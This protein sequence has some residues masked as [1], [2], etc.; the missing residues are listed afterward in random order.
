MSSNRGQ[1]DKPFNNFPLHDTD[2]LSEST[3]SRPNRTLLSQSVQSKLVDPHDLALRLS[4]LYPSPVRK[5]RARPSNVRFGSG[6]DV[7]R[8]HTGFP[9]LATSGRVGSVGS[10]LP[11]STRGA[12]G[13]VVRHDRRCAMHSGTMPRRLPDIYGALSSVLVS[14]QTVGYTRC[15]LFTFDEITSL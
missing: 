13:G 7:R 1:R 15:P 8:A 12:C 9:L 6:T 14:V 2:V 5:G 4:S 11:S 3:A 10:F